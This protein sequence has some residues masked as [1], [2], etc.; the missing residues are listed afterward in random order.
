[1]FFWVANSHSRPQQHFAVHSAA[2]RT[3]VMLDEH[4]KTMKQVEAKGTTAI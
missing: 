2:L 4:R 3:A 1:M